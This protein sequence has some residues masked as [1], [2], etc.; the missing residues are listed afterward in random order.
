MS[1]SSVCLQHQLP[2]V[3]PGPIRPVALQP[4]DLIRGHPR[5]A[6][7]AVGAARVEV[8]GPTASVVPMFGRHRCK[9]EGR[10]PCSLNAQPS[11]VFTLHGVDESE[12]PVL[13]RELR[14]G[15]V[16]AFFAKL[17]PSEVV[18]G[19]CGAAHR[20]GCRLSAPGHTVKLVPPQYVKPEP[21]PAKAGVK[22][23]KNG[24]IRACPR[25]GQGRTRGPRR[26]A[27]R[28]RGRRCALCR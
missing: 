27:R 13:R 10:P 22:H 24:R 3:V 17:E 23:G 19:A 9:R 5:E 28:R 6:G 12:R 11:H 14:R 1:A 4:T 8:D 2:A 7:N 21:A 16:E 20:W 26:S 18:L 15:Q 25:A